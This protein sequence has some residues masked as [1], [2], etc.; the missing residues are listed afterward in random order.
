MAGAIFTLLILFISLLPI[1]LSQGPI[2][3]PP[4]PALFSSLTPAPAPAPASDICNGIFISYSYWGGRR[5]PPK[6]KDDPK[7]QPYRFQSALTVLNNGEEELKSWKVFVGFQHEELLVSATNAV[8]ADGTTTLPALVGNGTILAGFPQNDLKTGIQTAGD[9]TQMSVVVRMVGTQFGV[10][11]PDVPLPFNISLVNDGYLCPET[12]MEGNMT[13][14][15]CCVLDPNAVPAVT[16]DTKFM[17]RQKGDLTILYDV[18]QTYSQNYWAKV[19]IDNHSPLGRLDYWMLKWDWMRDEFIYSMRGAYPYVIDMNECLFGPQA[20]IYSNPDLNTGLNCHRSP[21]LVDLPP[22]KANDTAL[23][24]VPFCCRNGTVLPPS[25]DPTKSSSAFMIQVYKMPPDFNQSALFP[26]QNWRIN[27]TL[28]PDYKC[29]PPVRVSPSQFVDSGGLPT[30][31]TAVASWQVVCNITVAKASSPKCCVSFSAYYNDSII[32]CPTCACGCPTTSSRTC[33]TKS[34]ALLIPPEA[35]LVPFENRTKLA[36]AWA[37]LKHRSVPNPLPCG[38]NCGV[39]INWHLLTDFS[40]GWT[41]RVTLF[42]WDD[43]I[44]PDWFV[45]AE[46]DKAAAG[47]EKAYSFNGTLMTDVND[48]VFLQGLP[49]LN[50]LLGETNG[51][52]PKKDPR[53]PGKQQSVMSFTKKNLTGLRIVAGDGFPT[54]VYFNGEECS[55][56]SV[57]P[58]S[59]G[60]RG[61]GRVSGVLLFVVGLLVMGI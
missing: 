47:F 6:L 58:M 29:G 49:G 59:G 50:Y 3:S 34:P 14:N 51:T 27:G 46:L 35:Q 56:P 54:K 8:I 20:Q 7:K 28:N 60:P 17:P 45:A 52:D 19:T 38:D 36:L 55:L 33:G 53:V 12:T 22:T 39:S 31:K 30:N 25:M 9:L 15:L 61:G 24:Y 18:T 48:T 26:P 23:G 21:V 4:S 10:K 1:T 2:P 32:P 40:K 44:F 13:M 57:I 43:N 42:N 37:Q 5:L 16:V 11:P 41:A